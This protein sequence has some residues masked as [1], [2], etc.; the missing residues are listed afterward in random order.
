MA[1]RDKEGAAAARKGETHGFAVFRGICFSSFTE[2]EVANLLGMQNMVGTIGSLVAGLSA[3]L[4]AAI[5]YDENQETSD[6]YLA[7]GHPYM[8]Y[9]VLRGGAWTSAVSFT[10]AMLSIVVSLCLYVALSAANFSGKGDDVLVQRWVKKHFPLLLLENV[11]IVVAV[12]FVWGTCYFIGITKYVVGIYDW[13]AI[14]VVGK[15]K[16]DASNVPC[17]PCAYCHTCRHGHGDWRGGVHLVHALQGH[18]ACDC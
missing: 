14:G 8:A 15:S 11:C 16:A 5:N 13:A 17:R 4:V 7:T 3:G 2:S 10:C 18:S 6:R 1:K 9:A 12:L